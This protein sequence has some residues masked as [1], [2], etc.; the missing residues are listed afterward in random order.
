MLQPLFPTF[1]SQLCLPTVMEQWRN[2]QIVKS[3][4]CSSPSLASC[5]PLRGTL[6]LLGHT[7]ESREM[8]PLYQT[9]VYTRPAMEKINATSPRG[10]Q[11]PRPP[12]SM[13]LVVAGAH[14]ETIGRSTAPELTCNVGIGGAG[15][16]GRSRVYFFHR[17]LRSL[18]LVESRAQSQSTTHECFR[19]VE[20][21]RQ[22][23]GRGWGDGRAA[24]RLLDGY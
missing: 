18:P 16:R 12:I 19:G 3:S 22:D 6:G 15:G 7:V 10:P 1:K 21:C 23:R 5:P 4:G 17:G 8:R 9:Y 13:L 2:N 24:I 14:V 11:P 20:Q